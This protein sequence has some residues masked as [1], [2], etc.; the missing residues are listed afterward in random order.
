MH[1]PSTHPPCML[2]KSLTSD[3]V[4]DERLYECLDLCEVCVLKLPDA[5]D[6][7]LC[8]L[9]RRW[10]CP[11]SH[12]TCSLHDFIQMQA[13]PAGELQLSMQS[14]LSICPQ[15]S[16]RRSQSPQLAPPAPPNFGR[17][18]KFSKPR[19]STERKSVIAGPVSVSL[20]IPARRDTTRNHEIT[21]SLT[22]S[23]SKITHNVKNET[24]A[25]VE[26]EILNL[27]LIK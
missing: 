19:Q 24:T 6:W 11:L 4:G 12:R 9:D 25:K 5:G 18:A 16:L 13:C 3:S 22:H 8:S 27:D 17:M 7:R 1:Y 23:V 15:P 20:L 2:W 14:P 21:K 10:G 26:I